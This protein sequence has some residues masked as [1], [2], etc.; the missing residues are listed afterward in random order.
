MGRV[1]LVGGS[2]GS[3]S[4]TYSAL[5]LFRYSGNGVRQLTAGQTAYFSIDGGKTNLDNFNTNS[6]GDWGD[7]AASAGEDSYD[8]FALPGV[9]NLVTA[10]D[11]SAMDVIGWDRAGSSSP[12]PP[13]ISPDGSILMAGSGGNLVTAAG[14]W[15]FSAATAAGGNVILLNGQPAAGGSA[16]ELE[17]AN[18]G[19]LCADNLQGQWWEWNGSGWSGSTDPTP[20]SVSSSPLV[21]DGLASP[22]EALYEPMLSIAGDANSSNNAL[23]RFDFTDTHISDS[24]SGGSWSRTDLAAQHA[25]PAASGLL[26]RLTAGS[27]GEAY[28]ALRAGFSTEHTA[29]L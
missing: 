8:A 5:D 10:S 16:S 4:N 26:E 15:T 29:I 20:A 28:S 22:G 3:T 2:L 19:H 13:P 11:L 7:W 18:Q 27:N 24:G 25:A 6:G 9:A 1:A 21:V 17:V 14:T 23:Q 12:P